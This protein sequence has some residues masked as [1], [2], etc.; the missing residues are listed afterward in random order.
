MKKLN[1]KELIEKAKWTRRKLFDVAVKCG[2]AH[3][4]GAL[5]SVEVLLSLYNG[6]ILDISPDSP[7]AKDRFIYSKGHNPLA[8]YTILADNGFFSFEDLEK[9]GSTTMPGH[10][11]Y[12]TNGIEMT[13]G[14]LGHGIGF[15][16]GIALANKLDKKDDKV[17]V[18]LGD[19]EC[20]EG[21]VW[22]GA[23][24][25][26]AK[27]LNNLIVIVDNNKFGV[28]EL[29]TNYTGKGLLSEKF[30]SFDWNTFECNGHSFVS[31]LYCLNQIKKLNSEQP[32]VVIANTIKGKGISFME[33]N[34]AW[35]HG[36]PKGEQLE[37]A[38]E[39]LK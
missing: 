15:G 24:F 22:E 19:T 33:N 9:Y 37:I 27:K 31:I 6:G 18:M 28:Q 26:A 39:E 10:L 13:N 2:Q 11:D 38:K 5:S 36:V 1:N 30:K 14:S 29:T 16:C 23:M 12:H 34:P 3:L 4:G 17:Y 8:L 32:N 20:N 21:S 25:A 35:H 7:E